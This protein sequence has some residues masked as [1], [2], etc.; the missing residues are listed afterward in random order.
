VEGVGDGHDAGHHWNRGTLQ[1][2]GVARSVP[3]F[4]VVAN[5]GSEDR[6]RPEWSGDLGA[7]DR[8]FLDLGEFF[9]RVA[10]L[11][12]QELLRQANLSDVMK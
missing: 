2:V 9:R 8:V 6:R 11:L 5:R 3:P 12:V 10:P 4:V 7:Q 1:L